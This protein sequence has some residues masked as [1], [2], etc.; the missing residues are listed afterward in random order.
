[1]NQKI[2]RLP[3]GIGGSFKHGNKS[4]DKILGIGIPDLLIKLL[5]FHDFLKNKN[6][7]V[8]SKYSKSMLEYYFSKL[9][10]LFYCNANNLEKFRMR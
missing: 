4:Y 6:P 8:I 7:V 9:F 10:T 3:V 1:M 5:S 2:S